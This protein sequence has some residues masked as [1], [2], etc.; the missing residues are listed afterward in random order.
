MIKKDGFEFQKSSRKHKKYMVRVNNK[1]VHF[2][3]NRYQHYKD[4]IGL[5]SMLDHGDIKRKKAYYAR[6]GQAVKHSPKWFSHKYLW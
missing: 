1:L 5:Y 6:H 2:G 3:D 4:K